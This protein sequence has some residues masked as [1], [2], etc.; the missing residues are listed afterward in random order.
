MI[1]KA[2]LLMMLV[3]ADDLFCKGKWVAIGVCKKG[4]AS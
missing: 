1:M 4:G 3:G 2:T